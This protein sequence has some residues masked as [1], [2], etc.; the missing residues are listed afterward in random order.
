LSERSPANNRPEI[1]DNHGRAHQ[2]YLAV[3]QRFAMA[4]SSRKGSRNAMRMQK[5]SGD[6]NGN[7]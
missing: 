7:G 6:E 3:S 4:R 2:R 1:F 5:T